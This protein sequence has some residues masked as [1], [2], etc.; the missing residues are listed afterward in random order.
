MKI[1]TLVP[2]LVLLACCNGRPVDTTLEGNMMRYASAETINFNLSG[3]TVCKRCST[4][5]IEILFVDFELVSR[6]DPTKVFAIATSPSTGPTT[7]GEVSA[8]AGSNLAVIATLHGANGFQIEGSAAFAMPV[9]DG[10]AATFF[11]NFE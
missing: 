6:D 2:F 3:T 11:I 7:F 4:S 8:I 1:A 9:E 5:D 10:G